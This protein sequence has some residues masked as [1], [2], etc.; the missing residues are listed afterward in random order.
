MVT[1]GLKFPRVFSYHLSQSPVLR[2]VSVHTG[3]ESYLVSII[4][5]GVCGILASH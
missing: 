1:T 3:A 5:R 4:D 2:H